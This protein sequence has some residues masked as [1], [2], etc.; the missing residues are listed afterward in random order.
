MTIIKFYELG[1]YFKAAVDQNVASSEPFS[2]NL[3]C[4]KGERFALAACA[5]GRISAIKLELTRRNTRDV[6]FKKKINNPFLFFQLI[7]C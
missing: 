2:T 4:P 7:C 1:L 5:P 3:W 6:C